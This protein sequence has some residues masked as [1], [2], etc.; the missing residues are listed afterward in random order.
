MPLVN[1]VDNVDNDNNLTSACLSYTI[2]SIYISIIQSSC[3]F[4]F[5]KI[6]TTEKKKKKKRKRPFAGEEK[7]ILCIRVFVVLCYHAYGP[8]NLKVVGE[9]KKIL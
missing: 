9:E 4:F 7:K 6:S 8:W 5:S 1:V 3:R 2:L